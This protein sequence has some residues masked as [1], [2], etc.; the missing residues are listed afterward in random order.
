[1]FVCLFDCDEGKSKIS[2]IFLLILRFLLTT[3]LRRAVGGVV[4]CQSVLMCFF[5]IALVHG[6]E[7]FELPLKRLE[8]WSAHW[9][10]VPTLEHDLVQRWIAVWWHWHAVPMF[11]LTQDFGVGHTLKT[12]EIGFSSCPN[13]TSIVLP[14]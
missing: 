6:E 10:F 11:H 14:G 7:V 3:G 12:R 4:V 2:S 8:R 1:V 5:V 13:G 9:V